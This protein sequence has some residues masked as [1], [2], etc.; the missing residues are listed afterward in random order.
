MNSWDTLTPILHLAQKSSRQINGVSSQF[1][2]YFKRFREKIEFHWAFDM[3]I[4]I[5]LT[6]FCVTSRTTYNFALYV[7]KN[8]VILHVRF[9]G[10]FWRKWMFLSDIS[11]TC[12][13]ITI[14]NMIL[15]NSTKR[16]LKYEK[17]KPTCSLHLEKILSRC[18][19]C[20]CLVTIDSLKQDDSHPFEKIIQRFY[21]K[22]N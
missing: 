4:K 6:K 11:D 20:C 16:K 15:E 7:S 9:G 1:F 22:Q 10:I 5:L 18:E 12:V 17:S 2:F 13:E 3:K 8:D 19:L 21:S 14:V